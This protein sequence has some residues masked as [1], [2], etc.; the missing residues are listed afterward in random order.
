[1]RD[2]RFDRLTVQPDD[3]S[4]GRSEEAADQRTHALWTGDG[5][6]EVEG[7]WTAR[8]LLVDWG[9]VYRGRTAQPIAERRQR[10]QT[11]GRE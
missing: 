3:G 2:E 10:R 4:R 6:V 9:V 8:M 1:M 7:R 11:L 5:I